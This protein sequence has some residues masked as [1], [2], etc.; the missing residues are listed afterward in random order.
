MFK[1]SIEEA[2]VH[3][4]KA[5]C[6]WKFHTHTEPIVIST[7]RDLCVEVKALNAVL[8]CIY[9]HYGSFVYLPISPLYDH[10]QHTYTFHSKNV[11]VF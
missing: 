4:D 1:E 2:A 5:A 6:V 3:V 8:V 9:T 10:N 7:G 11:G